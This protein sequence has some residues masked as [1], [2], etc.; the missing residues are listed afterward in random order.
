M[1][2]IMILLVV[3]PALVLCGASIP[4]KDSVRNVKTIKMLYKEYKNG[5][6]SECK[7]KGK[8]VC[9]AVLNAYDAASHIYDT[10]GNLIGT[11]N[12]AWGMPDPICWELTDFEVIYRVKKIFGVNRV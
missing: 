6:I 10:E 11:C 2:K 9:R 5:E 1:K 7:Y 8:T 12:Y 4:K 3:V